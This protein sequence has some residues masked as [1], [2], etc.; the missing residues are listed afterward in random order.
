MDL[1]LH[2]IRLGTDIKGK[3]VICCG[4]TTEADG[5]KYLNVE[6]YLK[7]LA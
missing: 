6:E 4:V 1:Y 3:Y 5:I 7:A 2:K